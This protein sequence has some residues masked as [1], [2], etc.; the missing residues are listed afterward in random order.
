MLLLG[1]EQAEVWR[2]RTRYLSCRSATNNRPID[3][4]LGAAELS[5]SPGCL[6]VVADSALSLPAFSG[7][8]RCSHISARHGLS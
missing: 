8:K 7:S 1:D 6:A 5:S 2:P 4:G 3:V